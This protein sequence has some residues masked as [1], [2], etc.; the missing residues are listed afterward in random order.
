MKKFMVAAIFA[1]MTLT[2]CG[3]GG[4]DDSGSNPTPSK[5][6]IAFTPVSDV[7]AIVGSQVSVLATAKADTGFRFISQ[8]YADTV[9]T[10][11][12]L[13]A[14][15]VGG[16]KFETTFVDSET[17]NSMT[18]TVDPTGMVSLDADHAIVEL[19]VT[20]NKTTNTKEYRHYLVEY[21]TGKMI[22]LETVGL[23]SAWT[24]DSMF[25]AAA[26][27]TI[28]NGLTNEIIFLKESR[29]WVAITPNWTDL[30][31]TSRVVAPDTSDNK[32]RPLQYVTIAANGDVYS[33]TGGNTTLNGNPLPLDVSNSTFQKDG[34]TY[35][36][37]TVNGTDPGIV[38]YKVENGQLVRAAIPAVEGQRMLTGYVIA[39][40]GVSVKTNGC[41]E[42]SLDTANGVFNHVYSPA[43]VE[44]MSYDAYVAGN[45]L[46]CTGAPV[47]YA[48]AARAVEAAKEARAPFPYDEVCDNAAGRTYTAIN[49]GSGVEHRID[50]IE[51]SAYYTIPTSRESAFMKQLVCVDAGGDGVSSAK[52]TGSYANT[53]VDFAANELRALSAPVVMA[54][55]N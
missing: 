34:V 41:E 3:G 32:S 7:S 54:V 36:A 53:E 5:G 46:V 33:T 55:V 49:V 39:F 44:T 47:S 15:D 23:A 19:F 48:K 12:Q 40:D 45:N 31:F 29:E 22:L 42:F 35:V 26:P 37:G 16:N 13:V 8:A 17:G 10:H 27:N 9:E 21:S 11:T 4:G 2:A 50:G 38:I 30:T 6:K 52:W 43:D 25:F 14:T 1:S 28:H 20:T 18:E 51:S 24:G